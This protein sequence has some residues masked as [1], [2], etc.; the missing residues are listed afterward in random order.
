MHKHHAKSS[1]S[2]VRERLELRPRGHFHLNQRRPGNTTP[3]NLGNAWSLGRWSNTHCGTQAV[4]DTPR[5]CE[6]SS[7]VWLSITW[8]IL[9]EQVSMRQKS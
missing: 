9:P 7:S 2:L 5:W 6:G 1:K 8:I 4:T 3:G